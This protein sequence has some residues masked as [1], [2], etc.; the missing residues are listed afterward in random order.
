KP[1]ENTDA[2]DLPDITLKNDN[3][4]QVKTTEGNKTYALVDRLQDYHVEAK[5]SLV[6][7]VT[8]VNDDSFAID[9]R[10][11]DKEDQDEFIRLYMKKDFSD[12]AFTS[13]YVNAFNKHAANGDLNEF[14]D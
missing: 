3:H 8:S 4:L 7:N 6:I 9:I 11:K 2:Y 1:I 10:N 14:I 5:D 13:T 12:M